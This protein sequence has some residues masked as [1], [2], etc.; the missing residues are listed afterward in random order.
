MEHWYLFVF[1][2]RHSNNI[3]LPVGHYLCWVE[4]SLLWVYAQCVAN[5]QRSRRLHTSTRMSFIDSTFWFS[6]FSLLWS[7][8][9]TRKPSNLVHRE[10][11]IVTVKSRWREWEAQKESKQKKQRGRLITKRS[12]YHKMIALIIVDL[13]K[14]CLFFT[15]TIS[16]VKVKHVVCIEPKLTFQSHYKILLLPILWKKVI[17]HVGRLQNLNIF[18]HVVWAFLLSQG[19]TV[20]RG[21]VVADFMRRKVVCSA[22]GVW[23]HTL[24][25][26]QPLFRGVAPTKTLAWPDPVQASH[27]SSTGVPRFFLEWLKAWGGGVGVGEEGLVRVWQFHCTPLPAPSQADLIK[28]S[29]RNLSQKAAN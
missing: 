21:E 1:L 14:V 2:L 11:G 5:L 29:A 4:T 24:P 12:F 13:L 15:D 17:Q 18:Q 8:C 7:L 10:S 25:T 16:N 6:F 20:P 27:Y 22:E 28:V 9:S 19:V 3:L 23:Q 26:D